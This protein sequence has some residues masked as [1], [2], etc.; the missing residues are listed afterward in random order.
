MSTGGSLPADPSD[1]ATAVRYGAREVRLCLII[2]AIALSIGAVGL[3]GAALVGGALR[4]TLVPVAGLSALYGLLMVLSAVGGAKDRFVFDAT[5]WWWF[6]LYGNTA[7]M[8]DSLAGVCIYS[9]DDAAA[10]NVTAT[11][12]LFP[13]GDF[14][15]DDPVLWRYVRDGDPPADGLP[16]LRYRVE[17]TRIENVT[18]DVEQACLRWVPA[19]LWHGNLLQPKGYQ[20]RA[21]HAG[22]R[23]RLRERSSQTPTRIAWDG[24]VPLDDAED[25][26]PSGYADRQGF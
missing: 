17:L 4:W 18:T 9:T 15:R 25:R 1:D 19:E 5:G 12:E 21:D 26:D 6:C 16:R 7:L 3:S 13:L 20:G 2:S 10:Q 22:H 14:D 23:R 24:S 8:W 11:L